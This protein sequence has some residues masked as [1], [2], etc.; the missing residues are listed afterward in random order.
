MVNGNGQKDSQFEYESKYEVNDFI[1]M[2]DQK[3]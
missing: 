2:T 1:K 3:M